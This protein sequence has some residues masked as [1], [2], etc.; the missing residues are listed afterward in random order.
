MS[1]QNIG[2]YEEMK[3]KYLSFIIS[4]SSLF[5]CVFQ[6]EE[7]DDSND[8]LDLQQDLVSSEPRREK[9]CLPGFRPSLTQ[10]GLM[11]RDMKFQI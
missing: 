2:F 7:P 9:T 5:F 4:V 10:T 11:A 1:T 6:T 3:K 8:L